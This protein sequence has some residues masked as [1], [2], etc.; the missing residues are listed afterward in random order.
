[1]AHLTC[2]VPQ[3]R[4]ARA[5]SSSAYRD[6]GIDNILALGGDPPKDL[7]LPEGE[8]EYAI[9]LVRL[10]ARGRRL[11]RSASPP[12]R[13]L[14]PRRR[15][16]RTTGAARP[17]SS[18]RPTS[19]SPSSSSTPT[20]T[21]TWWRACAALGVDKPV[22]PGIMPVTSIASVKRMAELQGVRVPGVARWP[23]SRPP[24]D[25]PADG[26]GGG[27]RPRPPSLCAEAARRRRAGPALLHDEPLHRD[28]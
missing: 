9:E 8:L 5:R 28:P 19:P 16:G 22:I 24:V 1:M 10:V 25:D 27:H 2:A 4:R 20:T 17:R 11:L 6:A 3:P 21:S 15:T 7:D 23:S 13:S 12:T 26:P 14:H 18:P